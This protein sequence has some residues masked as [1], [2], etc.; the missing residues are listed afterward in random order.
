MQRSAEAY[1]GLASWFM[2]PHDAMPKA[3]AA[4]ETAIKLDHS[5]ALRARRTGIHPSPLLRIGM[6]LRPSGN[7][8]VPSS[9]ILVAPAPG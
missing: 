5:L 4:A 7:Y 8:N 2:H 3:K 6:G 9:S 1:I